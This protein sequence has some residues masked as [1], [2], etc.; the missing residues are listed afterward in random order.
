M[1]FSATLTEEVQK[2][3]SVSLKDPVKLMV[4]ES[5]S[6]ALALRQEFV[7]VREEDSREA[8][9]LSMLCRS[10]PERTLVFIPTKVQV[11]RL[12]AVLKVMGK[13]AVELHGNMSQPQVKRGSLNFKF[14]WIYLMSD[15]I[16][17]FVYYFSGWQR[18]MTLKSLVRIFY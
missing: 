9:L 2:L 18:W 16:Y 6:T 17:V 3:A 1:L 15:N 7:R 10:F 11:H 5:G 12:Y 4:D 14:I 13:K 8:L